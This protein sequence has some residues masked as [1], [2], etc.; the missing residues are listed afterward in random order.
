ML[1]SQTI[2][3]RLHTDTKA[4]LVAVIRQPDHTNARHRVLLQRFSQ[5]II[6][7]TGS[8]QQ[9]DEIADA[10][11]QHWFRKNPNP[12][13]EFDTVSARQAM[14]YT[15]RCL[16]EAYTVLSVLRDDSFDHLPQD[17]QTQFQRRMLSEVK[18]FHEGSNLTNNTD[19][20]RWFRCVQLD[21]LCR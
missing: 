16:R 17:E 2:F 18:K 8:A 20:V 13:R 19:Q 14:G 4:V 6:H 11:E 9:R 21:R 5:A 15:A 12:T 3:E 10:I 7:Q 1:S